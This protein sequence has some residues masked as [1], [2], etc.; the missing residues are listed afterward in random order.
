MVS[1]K[2]KTHSR[3]LLIQV[4]SWRGGHQDISFRAGNVCSMPGGFIGA[5]KVGSLNYVE[6][7]SPWN[8]LFA[9]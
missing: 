1:A 3:E 2:K 9:S 6:L 8:L 5:L 4:F 7:F